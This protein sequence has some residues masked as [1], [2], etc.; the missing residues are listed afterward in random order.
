VAYKTHMT[1][2]E[3]LAECLSHDGLTQ[4]DAATRLGVKQPTVQ[5]WVTGKDVP[6]DR[7]VETIASLTGLTTARVLDAIHRQRMQR[8]TL[9]ERVT[10]LEG[11]ISELTSLIRHLQARIEQGS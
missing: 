9:P 3:V 4:D 5:R 8:S 2:S 6:S 10:A 11:Q 7:Y 1:I